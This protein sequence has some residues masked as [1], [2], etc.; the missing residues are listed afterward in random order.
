MRQQETITLPG[1]RCE[2][3]AAVLERVNEAARQG[4][5]IKAINVSP[6]DIVVVVKDVF[7]RSL[8]G[9]VPRR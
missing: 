6:S 7:D 1:R 2:K 8:M 5:T 4:F 9:V 3:T